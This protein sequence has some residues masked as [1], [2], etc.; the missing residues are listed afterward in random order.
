MSADVPQLMRWVQTVRNRERERGLDGEGLA[1]WNEGPAIWTSFY[2]D[3]PTPV[4]SL[5]RW[6]GNFARSRKQA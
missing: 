2:P 6:T 4:Q 5:R 1:A 3:P